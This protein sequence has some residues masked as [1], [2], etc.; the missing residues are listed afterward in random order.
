MEADNPQ[1]DIDTKELPK[2]YLILKLR[3]IFNK[4]LYLNKTITYEIYN[5]MQLLLMK[6]MDKIILE[7]VKKKV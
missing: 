2:E 5:K 1:I 7:N 4:Q 3:I 6:K